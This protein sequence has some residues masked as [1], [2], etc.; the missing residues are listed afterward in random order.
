[1]VKIEMQE[2]R[3]IYTFN[4]VQFY[5]KVFL[6]CTMSKISFFLIFVFVALLTL[7]L[8]QDSQTSELLSLS[9]T[10]LRSISRLFCGEDIPNLSHRLINKL[11]NNSNVIL[12]SQDLCHF[13]FTMLNILISYSAQGEIKVFAAD[14]LLLAF[15]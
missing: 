4:K 2:I 8:S 1:M 15:Q 7:Q 9:L 3:K 13:V 11:I 6:L 14:L 10:Q 5:G 12:G